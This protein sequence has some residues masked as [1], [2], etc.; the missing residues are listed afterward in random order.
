MDEYCSFYSI[1]IIVNKILNVTL[2]LLFAVMEPRLNG[3]IIL[4]PTNKNFY[5]GLQLNLTCFV[6][7]SYTIYD[8]VQ[9][10]NIHATWRRSGSAIDND[11]DR[12][13]VELFEMEAMQYQTSVIFNSLDKARDDGQY[14]L[15]AVEAMFQ[16]QNITIRKRIQL[17]HTIEVQSEFIVDKA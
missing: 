3:S 2:I 1:N 12:N 4:Y 9:L 14:I 13:V 11:F 5:T 15:C 8:H 6:I 7:I 16:Q 17:S 10:L